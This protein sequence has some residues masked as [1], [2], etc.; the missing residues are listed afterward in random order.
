MTQEPISTESNFLLFSTAFQ[1]RQKIP[2]K[3]TCDGVNVSPQ[4]QWT[5]APSG[6][7]T[8]ALIV[9]D[10]D[11]PG[12]VFT[13]WVLFNLPADRF[14]LP[15]GISGTAEL[16]PNHGTTGWRKTAY[17]GPCPP[18]GTHHYIFTLYA[19]DAALNLSAGA[20]KKEVLAALEGHVL[21]T[22]ELIGLYSR[23]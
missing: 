22:T 18:S 21:A 7:K 4:L 9:D 23:Q 19:S 3:Y 17:G 15:E 12:G 20:S 10:P 2:A 8:F 13:H 5:G 16:K 11:A 14:E 1:N 6:T